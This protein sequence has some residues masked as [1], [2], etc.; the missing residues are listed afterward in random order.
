MLYR[1]ALALALLVALALLTTCGGP[2]TPT[3]TTTTSSTTTSSTSTTSVTTTSVNP[4]F[5]LYGYVTDSR[6]ARAVVGGRVTVLDGPNIDKSSA[7]DGNGY[8]SIPGVVRGG[9]TARATA[10]G[11]IQADMGIAVTSD[12]QMNFILAPIA[13]TTVSTTS[14]T[15]PVTGPARV[16]F[17]TNSTTCRCTVGAITVRVDGGN[18][19]SMSCSG[20]VSVGVSTGAHTFN[21][22]DN[23]GCFG[24]ARATLNAGDVFIY[25]ATCSGAVSSEKIVR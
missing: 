6:T 21:A 1:S 3:V 12:T 19:G 14:V 24:D 25:T 8:Y 9:F 22:C 13:T 11:Y 7:T 16:D 4:T 20:S 15:G 10:S 23:V 2:S 18:A 5:T 17:R